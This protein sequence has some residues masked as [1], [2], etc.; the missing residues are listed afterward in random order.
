MK[1]SNQVNYIK[2]DKGI[3]LIALIVTVIVLAILVGVTVGMITGNS[4]IMNKTLNATDK[5]N[6]LTAEEKVETEVVNSYGKN[7]K[8]DLDELNENLKNNIKGIELNGSPISDSNKIQSLPVTVVVDGYEV[9]IDD[10]TIV[11]LPEG[12][13]YGDV[14]QDGIVSITDASQV[15][16]Y[17]DGWVTFTE[18]QKKAAEVSGDGEITKLDAE[19]IQLV[20][21]NEIPA[22]PV[23]DPNVKYYTLGD[24]NR[25]G[26]IDANDVSDVQNYVT[27]R[28]SIENGDMISPF[29]YNEIGKKTAD[30]DGDGKVTL[31][32]A[33]LIQ[34][35]LA[36][37]IPAFPAEDSSVKYYT[38]GDVNR[39]GIINSK[40]VQ[41]IQE[42]V[43]N[44]ESIENGDME[45]P[46][47]EY[48][49]EIR[50]KAA[51]ID[52]DGDIDQNDVNELQK[53]IAN[54]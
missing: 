40:D 54:T 24:V 44:K 42:Y 10:E 29:K 45:S 37:G 5:T 50:K 15:Q 38:L 48:Y 12:F 25:N 27:N 2:E 16:N 46:F 23:E 35:L 18:T 26:R 4:G 34:L 21:G 47:G 39:D 19:L 11:E 52:G 17:V 31:L 43:N 32:D 14:N 49:P 51:D 41:I 36:K 53:M 20:D 7:G 33:D 28:E 8:I 9:V 3:T 30:V 13:K 1:I 22:F 6:Q